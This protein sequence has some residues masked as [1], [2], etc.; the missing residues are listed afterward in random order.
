MADE[1]NR[2]AWRFRYVWWEHSSWQTRTGWFFVVFLGIGAALTSSA[3]FIIL[4][5]LCIG[6][7]QAT[8]R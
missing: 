1:L 4:D 6:L 2:T 7:A 3:S 8:S 5:F